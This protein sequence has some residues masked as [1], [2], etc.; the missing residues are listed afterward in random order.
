MIYHTHEGS[1]EVNVAT[2]RRIEQVLVTRLKDKHRELLYQQ[3]ILE[4][5][6]AEQAALEKR[7]KRTK[8]PEEKKEL[9]RKAQKH[10]KALEGKKGKFLTAFGEWKT[11]MLKLDLDLVKGAGESK[12]ES[13]EESQEEM[14]RH[15]K[16]TLTQASF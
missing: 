11:A 3:M 15:A 1:V 9:E 8:D 14:E 13:K 6:K 16:Y 5:C 7:I 2:T 4:G 10:A 12:E